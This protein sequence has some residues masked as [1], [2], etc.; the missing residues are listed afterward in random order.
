[1]NIT[2]A[3]YHFIS[4]GSPIWEDH[5]AFVVL[6]LFTLLLSLISRNASRITTVEKRCAQLEK[7][8]SDTMDKIISLH[9]EVT[10]QEDR[11]TGSLLTYEG[12]LDSIGAMLGGKM[13]ALS[14]FVR[15]R[16]LLKNENKKEV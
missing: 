16:V 4:E 6:F 10:A 1:M 13:E 8:A 11:H 9:N 12:H 15:N 14:D 5:S 3:V 2:A 7:S